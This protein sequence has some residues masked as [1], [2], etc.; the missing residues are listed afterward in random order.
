MTAASGLGL[1]NPEAIHPTEALRQSF[2][3]NDVVNLVIG[4]PALL[5][6]LWLA[7]RGKV[8]G[9]L[10]WPGALMFVLYTYLAYIFSMPIGWYYLLLLTLIA[11]N[12]AAFRRVARAKS[13]LVLLEFGQTPTHPTHF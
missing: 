1:L 2:F 10:F 9:L 5:V 3:A 12:F 4:L 6:A 8:V 13:Q 11:V 7:W